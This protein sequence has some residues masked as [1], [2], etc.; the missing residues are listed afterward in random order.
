MK[1][2]S[3]VL[4]IGGG[5]AGLSAALFLGNAKRDVL[6]VDDGK[7]RNRKALVS[8]NVLGFEAEP[9][10]DILQK[11]RQDIEPLQ[12]VQAILDQI[13]SIEK[14]KTEGFKS[15]LGNGDLIH[16]KIIVFAVGVVDILPTIDSIKPFWP[17]NIFHCPYCIAPDVEGEPLAI[18]TSPDELLMMTGIIKKWTNDLVVCTNGSVIQDPKTLKLFNEHHIS[19]ITKKI[20]SVSGKPGQFITFHFADGQTLDRRGV[21]IHL[22]FEIKSLHL[23]DQLNCELNDEGLVL[24]NENYQ[25]TQS[26]IY[27]IGDCAHPIQKISNAMASGTTAGFHIDHVLSEQDFIF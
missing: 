24:V 27:A 14:L 9:P 12:S 26:L 6:V 8:H 7:T 15:S 11:A 13:I 4:I 18:I 2:K 5:Y 23:L 3:D 22:P 17:E 16:A 20:L 25:T 21:F 1:L 19:L 10:L